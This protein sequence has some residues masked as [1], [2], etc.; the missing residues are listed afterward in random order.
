MKTYEKLL[1][2]RICGGIASESNSKYIEG[3]YV[4]CT[5]CYLRVERVN[6]SQCELRKLWNNLMRKEESVEIL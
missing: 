4:K 3:N 2:C 6:A 1:P 5:G